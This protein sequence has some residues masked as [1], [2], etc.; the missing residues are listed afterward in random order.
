MITLSLL[1]SINLPLQIS[2]IWITIIA[3]ALVWTY[4]TDKPCIKQREVRKFNQSKNKKNGQQKKN[5]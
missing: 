5:D 1:G 3:V 2:I 4:C